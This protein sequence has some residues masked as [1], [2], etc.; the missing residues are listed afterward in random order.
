M[1]VLPVP[2]YL[3]LTAHGVRVLAGSIP[4]VIAATLAAVVLLIGLFVSKNRQQYAMAVA[5]YAATFAIAMLGEANPRSYG[6]LS[7]AKQPM[8]QRYT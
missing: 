7:S 3:R 8:P 4:A 1:L 5:A 2:T 6:T